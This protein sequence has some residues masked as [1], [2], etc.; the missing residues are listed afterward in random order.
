MDKAACIAGLR[1]SFPYQVAISIFG[2]LTGAVLADAGMTLF[3]A[4]SMSV[5][6]LAGAS[7]LATMQ[8]LQDGS[9]VAVILVTCICMNLRFGMY[10]ASVAPYLKG[11]PGGHRIALAPFIHD[12][13][14]G[15]ALARFERVSEGWPARYWFML[16]AGSLT[17]ALWVATTGLGHA[18][19]ARVPESWSIDFAMPVIFIA[20]TVPFLRGRPRWV[21][22]I[23]ASGAALA[24][25]DLPLDTGLLAATALGIAAGFW[26]ARREARP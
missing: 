9:P 16:A 13:S 10:S 2:M 14:Y 20:M 15:V 8:M 12:Q 11:T 3:E 18:L 6:V 7:Q 24:L 23:V 4:L 21:A 22:A 17:G 1:A 25:R 19:G 26:V 5:I